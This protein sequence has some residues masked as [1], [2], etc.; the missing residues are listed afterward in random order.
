MNMGGETMFPTWGEILLPLLLY[1]VLTFAIPFMASILVTRRMSHVSMGV[2]IGIGAVTGIV[3]I[4]AVALSGYL[5][6]MFDWFLPAETPLRNLV[7]PILFGAAG[8]I[9]DWQIIRRMNEKKA[10]EIGT[11]NFASTSGQSEIL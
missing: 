6:L 5:S 4:I 11:S 3:V 9:V 1:V 8:G 7:R 2:G 10:A